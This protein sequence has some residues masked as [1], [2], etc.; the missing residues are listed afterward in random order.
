MA[1]DVGLENFVIHLEFSE[2]FQI[3]AAELSFSILDSLLCM[4]I[5][6]C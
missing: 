2:F 3:L 5:R 6:S 1:A 4:G